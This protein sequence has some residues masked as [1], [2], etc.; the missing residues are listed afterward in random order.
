[1]SVGIRRAI[2][3]AVAGAALLAG[4]SAGSSANQSAVAGGAAIPPK[5]GTPQTGGQTATGQSGSG[6]SGSGQSGTTAQLPPAT[7]G[8]QVVRTANIGLKSNN[9]SQTVDRA[10]QAATTAGGYASDEDS[11]P[12]QGSLTLKVPSDKLESV[13]G[14]LRQLSTQPATLSEHAEDVTDQVV[15]VT[16]RLATQQAS[17]ARVRALLDKATSLSDVTEIEGELTKREADLESLE[18]RH[19]ELQN[20]VAMS[21]IT[22]DI[23]KADTAPPPPAQQ[24]G[25]LD[26]LS[27]GWHAMLATL[28]G[29]G[30]G[31]GA[32]LPF[33]T[34]FGIPA[35]A[36]L[37]IVRRRR[38]VAG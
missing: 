1:M 37:W 7:D 10:Q 17:V 23:S 33:A 14:Q 13:L 6:Q 15:D 25:F 38:K 27:G 16:S 5:A 19:D 22:V 12:D 20:Q 32:V 8:R 18:Q 31:L 30:I 3:L 4:C 28:N 35:L 11:G 9:I 36:V 26:A 24:A 34:V 29:I 2:V 21:T